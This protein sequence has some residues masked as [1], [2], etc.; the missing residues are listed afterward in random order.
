MPDL[1]EPRNEN[2]GSAPVRQC[3]VM[4]GRGE[5]PIPPWKYH[6]SLWLIPC[7]KV[8]KHQLQRQTVKFVKAFSHCRPHFA[9]NGQNEKESAIA[10]GFSGLC[11]GQAPAASPKTNQRDIR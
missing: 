5:N 2:T 8:K 11:A 4:P 6:Q 7:L 3:G 1:L 9:A 10:G